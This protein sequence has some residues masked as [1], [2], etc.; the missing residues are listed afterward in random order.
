MR[1][2]I[3]LTATITPNINTPY[4]V[5]L[6]SQIREK[7]YIKTLKKIIEETNFEDIIFCENSNY[8]FM[9]EFNE[10]KILASI[11][12]KN[13]ELLSFE[14]NT[15]E[16]IKRG[17]GYGEGELIKYALFNSKLLKDESE[18]FFKLTGRLFIENINTIL[19]EKE[20]NIF[21]R[22]KP[23]Y[24]AVDTRFFKS[25]IKF[26]KDNL[27]NLYEK[28]DDSNLI[29]LEHCFY[30]KIK[31]FDLPSFKCYPIFLGNSGSTGEEYKKNKELFIM[32]IYN[33]IGLL[34]VRWKLREEINGNKNY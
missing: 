32:N 21:L 15:A 3:L 13:L 31:K 6:D 18:D 5:L 28:V 19:K 2:K 33:K 12:N 23:R 4:T 34:R 14:G 22:Y 9:D 8:V 11:R 1:R 30:N 17:K 29:Y 20:K 10:L 24:K 25:N 7:Q 16:T 27:I 26:Y